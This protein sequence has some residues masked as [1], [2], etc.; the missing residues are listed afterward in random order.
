MG[1]LLEIVRDMKWLPGRP[2][3]SGSAAPPCPVSM[4]PKPCQAVEPPFDASASAVLQIIVQAQ[5][6][7]SHPEIMRQMLRRGHDKIAA[8]QAIARCQKGC[9]IEHNLETGY[10]LS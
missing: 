9:R 1:R 3:V 8:R 4:P 7:V 10:I 2:V 5:L 6:P